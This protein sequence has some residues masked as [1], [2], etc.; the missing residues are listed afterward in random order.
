MKLQIVEIQV[1]YVYVSDAAEDD[2]IHEEILFCKLLET[3]CRGVDIFNK[4][5]ENLNKFKLNLNNCIGVCTDRAPSMTGRHNG[6]YSYSEG[7]RKLHH[8]TLHDT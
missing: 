7:I 5:K 1:N 4:L 6:L 8:D 2:G 3:T